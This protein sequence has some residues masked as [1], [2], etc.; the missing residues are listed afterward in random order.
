[1][2][3]LAYLTLVAVGVAALPRTSVA[4]SLVEASKI[5][6][7]SFKDSPPSVQES[8]EYLFV[9]VED[10]EDKSA[11]GSINE[12]VLSAQL[13]AI[14]KYIGDSKRRVVSPFGE[15][16]T[17]KM[18]A[19][20]GFKIPDAKRFSVERKRNGTT[21][22]DVT[23]FELAPIK[24]VRES[25]SSGGPEKYGVEEW[26]SLLRQSLDQCQSCDEKDEFWAQ[27]GATT[28]LMSSKGGVTMIGDSV[29]FTEVEAA[30]KEWSDKSSDRKSCDAILSVCPSFAP[31]HARLSELDLEDGDL[32]RSLVKALKANAAHGD[33]KEIVMTRL[34]EA[35]KRY[36]CSAWLEFSKCAE[37]VWGK[38]EIF[39]ADKGIPRYALNS[40]GRISVGTAP[41]NSTAFKH[42]QALFE[43]GEDLPKI[44][45]LM[46]R[47]VIDRPNDGLVW[48]YYGAALRVAG[49]F[50]DAVVAYNQALAIKPD[51]W[52]AA[53]DLCIVYQ[54]LGYK[55]LAS[56][57]A[58]HVA[59]MSG[60]DSATEK[61]KKILRENEKDFLGD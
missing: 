9:I 32:I 49:K 50:L 30:I 26:L 53:A 38:S 8:G 22:R 61:A 31:A 13:D 41:R 18:V 36:G 28:P 6:R 11:D 1:M 14:E 60:D 59:A 17:E 25:V 51:D 58:W 44:L 23:A 48:R 15:T 35:G 47:A 12:L 20:R 52:V 33:R 34:S 42:A 39:S 10:S 54:K 56:G 5:Y 7:G 40:F 16:I 24:A 37:E 19:L 21:F 3:K 46:A 29:D 43:K 55:E 45:T 2:N 4:A 27:I 57:N